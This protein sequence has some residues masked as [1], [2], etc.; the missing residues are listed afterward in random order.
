ML[1]AA[2]PPMTKDQ[3]KE[4]LRREMGRNPHDVYE[5]KGKS[6]RD[7]TIGKKRWRYEKPVI[8]LRRAREPTGKDRIQDAFSAIESYDI[9][10]ARCFYQP[11]P[12][13]THPIPIVFRS[14]EVKD[15]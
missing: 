7:V 9:T 10:I 13:S 6:C 12:S 1:D 14:S 8:L 5:E 2:K 11:H 15:S 3:R 4:R